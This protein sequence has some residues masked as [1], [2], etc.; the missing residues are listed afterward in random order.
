MLHILGFKYFANMLQ[1]LVCYVKL[2]KKN[3]KTVP[4]EVSVWKYGDNDR[5][6][7]SCG[8]VL[9]CYF[10]IAKCIRLVWTI[11]CYLIK[12]MPFYYNIARHISSMS[13]FFFNMSTTTFIAFGSDCWLQS[14]CSS[15]KVFATVNSRCGLL[16]GV[17]AF[18]SCFDGHR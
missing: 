12:I 15:N 1:N 6:N 18:L 5:F 2:E 9:N 4:F 17:A 10:N 16:L 11:L 13:F 8:H 7:A 14:S 3:N